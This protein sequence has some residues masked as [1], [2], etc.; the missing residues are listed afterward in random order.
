MNDYHLT[1]GS[2]CINRGT[3]E[4][5]MAEACDMDGQPRRFDDVVDIGANEA[6]ITWITGGMDAVVTTQWSVIQGGY[7]RL[8]RT[9]DLQNPA[10]VAV[11]SNVYPSQLMVETLVDTNPPSGPAFYRLAGLKE[12]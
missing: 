6:S 3:N 5:W 8:E 7:Y 10:W 2:P 9:G 4:T 12:K 11:A 1:C